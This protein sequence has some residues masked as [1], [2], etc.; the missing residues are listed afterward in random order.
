MLPQD[1]FPSVEWK[2]FFKGVQNTAFTRK[3]E[4]KYEIITLYRV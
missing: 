2:T 1:I 3:Y 4:M